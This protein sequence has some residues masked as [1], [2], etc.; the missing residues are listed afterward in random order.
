LPLLAVKGLVGVLEL[1]VAFLV[2]EGT[3]LLVHL[4]VAEEGLVLK[5]QA[6]AV[7]QVQVAEV[8]K[9]DKIR[10]LVMELVQVV[11]KEFL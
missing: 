4:E 5:L 8:L 10:G 11:A 6:L 2:Q 9:A 3:E 1:L 7:Y